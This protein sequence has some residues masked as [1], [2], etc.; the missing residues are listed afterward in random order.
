M[1][2]LLAVWSNIN[3]MEHNQTYDTC[4]QSSPEIDPEGIKKH[5]R[6]SVGIKPTI[7][8]TLV[9]LLYHWTTQPRGARLWDIIYRM[10]DSGKTCRCVHHTMIC[11]HGHLLVLSSLTVDDQCRSSCDAVQSSWVVHHR[12]VS[13]SLATDR[14]IKEE[15][16]AGTLVM[17]LFSVIS[18][19][20]IGFVNTSVHAITTSLICWW[21][22]M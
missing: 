22:A 12:A 5:L 3:F 15:N 17:S 4:I 6:T 16:S 21:Y 9:W 19:S 8:I 20:Y 14:G 2:S 13:E 18:M 1:C 7:F 10:Y 11:T